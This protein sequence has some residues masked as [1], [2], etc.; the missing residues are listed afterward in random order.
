M[1]KD[2][3]GQKHVY[4]CVCVCA[5]MCMCACMCAHVCTYVC[6]CVCVGVRVHVRICLSFRVRLASIPANAPKWQSLRRKRSTPKMEP[7]SSIPG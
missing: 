6:V 5:H 7:H 1:D 3:L 2:S 4:V